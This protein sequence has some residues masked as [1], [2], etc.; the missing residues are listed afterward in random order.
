MPCSVI[1]FK[2]QLKSIS[3]PVQWFECKLS[4][5]CAETGNTLLYVIMNLMLSSLL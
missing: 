1:C 2:F 4:L 5:Q 3:I